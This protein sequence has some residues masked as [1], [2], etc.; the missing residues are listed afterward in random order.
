MSKQKEQGGLT[1]ITRVLIISLIKNKIMIISRIGH[2]I[3]MHAEQG[4]SEKRHGGKFP[5]SLKIYSS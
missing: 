3:E 1:L 2:L 4:S 5:Q